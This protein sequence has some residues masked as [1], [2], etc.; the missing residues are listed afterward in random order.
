MPVDVLSCV[1]CFDPVLTPIT[2][3][4]FVVSATVYAGNCIATDE[5]VVHV[6]EDF[7]LFV[8]NV[9]SPND[10]NIN[11]FVSVFSD[12]VTARVLEF[13]IFDR[14][15]EKVFRGTDFAVNEPVLGWDGHF[16]GKIMNPAVF[17]YVAK[18]QFRNGTVR[19]VSGDITL[20]R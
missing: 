7:T 8:P 9:F 11:D 15:G 2:A 5:L 4:S 18:V 16:K 19:T 20:I 14:W 1:T 3:T 17:V 13:E 6:D 12:D 10:D